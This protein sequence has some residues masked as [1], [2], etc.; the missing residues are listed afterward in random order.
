MLGARPSTHGHIVVGED[1][2]Q[3]FLGSNGIR[4]KASKPAHGGWREHD[5]EIVRHDTGVSSDGANSNGVSL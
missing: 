4:G 5:G 2:L 1:F 3:L